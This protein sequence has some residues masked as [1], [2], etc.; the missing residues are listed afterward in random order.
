[1]VA[2]IGVLLAV[3]F[4][5]FGDSSRG[6]PNRLLQVLPSDASYP[7]NLDRAD[8]PILQSTTSDSFFR[9]KYSADRRAEFEVV[10]A[11]EITIFVPTAGVEVH[12]PT[13]WEVVSQENRGEVWHLP[14]ASRR[15]ICFERPY[16]GL[17][18]AF[19][20]Y[21]APMTGVKRLGWR[22]RRAWT[23]GSFSGWTNFMADSEEHVLY[24]EVFDAQPVEPGDRR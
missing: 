20:R 16:F 5:S 13:G 17:W 1:M 19:I 22:V 21:H 14:A 7:P 10:S 12:G 2:V 15:D 4:L 9:Y 3:A 24:S 23:K 6:A 11:R 8:I 18:R